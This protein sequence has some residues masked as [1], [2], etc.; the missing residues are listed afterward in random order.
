[1]AKKKKI[2]NLKVEVGEQLPSEFFDAVQ[3]KNRSSWGR[4]SGDST[5]VRLKQGVYII[6]AYNGKE[7]ETLAFISTRGF[8]REHSMCLFHS[9]SLMD[10]MQYSSRHNKKETLLEW[11]DREDEERERREQRQAEIDAKRKQNSQNLLK[12][13]TDNNP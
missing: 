1:M 12:G 3:Y 9:M 13:L 2:S 7:A 8:D 6:E 10:L 4:P 11:W 5:P